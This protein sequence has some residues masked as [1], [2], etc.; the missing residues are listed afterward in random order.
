MYETITQAV[1]ICRNTYHGKTYHLH[2][3]ITG[4]DL[5]GSAYDVLSEVMNKALGDEEFS[6]VPGESQWKEPE[7]WAFIDTFEAMLS[8]NEG[9]PYLWER[10]A[11]D[12]C[13]QIISEVEDK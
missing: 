9:R 12:L 5:T 1:E 4:E 11:R 10:K 3:E 6:Y 13:N 2:D 8:F 7:T